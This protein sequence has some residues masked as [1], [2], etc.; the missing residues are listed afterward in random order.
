VPPDLDAW[1]TDAPGPFVTIRAGGPF[2]GIVTLTAITE[3]HGRTLVEARWTQDGGMQS[4]SIEV[5]SYEEAR[6]V[7]HSAA[8]ELAVGHAPDLARD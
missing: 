2:E 6:T 8:A 7:A 4:N 1:Q 3:G 5:D